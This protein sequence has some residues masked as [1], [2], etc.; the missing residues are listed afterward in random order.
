MLT[1]PIGFLLFSINNN[2]VAK[3]EKQNEKV[4]IESEEKIKC[5]TFRSFLNEPWSQLKYKKDVFKDFHS[6]YANKLKDFNPSESESFHI[7]S[8]RGEEKLNIF[9]NNE[10]S[11]MNLEALEVVNTKIEKS[12]FERLI[13]AVSTKKYFKK[14]ILFNC[15]IREVPESISKLK[16]LNTL[17]LSKNKIQKLPSSI[18]ELNNLKYLR[19]YQNKGFDMIP[20]EIGELKNLEMF[21]FAGTSVKVI[22]SSIGSCKKLNHITGNASN[23]NTI[24]KEIGY[25]ES[26]IYINLEYNSIVEIPDELGNL[27][28]ESLGLGNNKIKSIPKS[29]ANLKNIWFLSFANNELTSF[30]EEVLELKKVV[31]LWLHGN[32]IKEIPIELADNKSL[33][34]LMVSDDEELKPFIEAIKQRNTKVKIIVKKD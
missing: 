32:D 10:D 4:E 19:L 1:I 27:P 3:E 34:S 29:I 26:L 21:D 9:F 5:D 11:F 24:P 23:V 16:T 13:D 15:E 33:V 7:V 14:L 28:L 22:P 17:D 20:H 2:E 18:R 12:T 6:P 31:N 25:C 30:P 8:I